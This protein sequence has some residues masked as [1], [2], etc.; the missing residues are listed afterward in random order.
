M[1]HELDLPAELLHQLSRIS[2]ATLSSQLIKRGHR[3]RFIETVAPANP[4]A[5]RFAGV[6]YT[7]RYIPAREDLAVAGSVA[8]GVNPQRVAIE[9]IPPGHVLVIDTRGELGSGTLGDIL[10][11]RLLQRGVAGVVSDGAMRDHE[12]LAKI[13]L[14]VFC[15]GFAAP[16]SY[17]RLMAADAGS[18]IG[19]GDVAVFPGDAVVGDADGVVVIPRHLAKDVARDAAAQEDVDRFVRT[20][21]DAGASTVGVYP[22]NEATMAEYRSWAAGQADCAK[23]E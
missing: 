22:P 20:R 15:R 10:V 3:R 2:T 4:R 13:D 1:A 17:G 18:P 21:I 16:P 9:T 19:C 12:E 5:A 6:A 11:A 8:G 23:G 14:P 7:L